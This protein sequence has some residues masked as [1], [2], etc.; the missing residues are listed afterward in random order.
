M[1]NDAEQEF[2]RV[3]TEKLPPIIARRKVDSLLGGVV[4]SKTLKNAD[5]TGTGPDVAY[6]VGR[7]IAYRTDSLLAWIVANLGV[8]K[9]AQ[10]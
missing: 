5:S 6:V 3:F 8:N 9:I 2:V 4:A 1:M 10:L 7:N